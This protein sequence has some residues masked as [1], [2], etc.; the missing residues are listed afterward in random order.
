MF[1]VSFPLY[2]KMIG[3]FDL[4]MVFCLISIITCVVVFTFKSYQIVVLQFWITLIKLLSRGSDL[5]TFKTFRMLE[6]SRCKFYVKTY[7]EV[8]FVAVERP[9]EAFTNILFS[10]GTTGRWRRR[11]ISLTN[12][13]DYWHCI[14]ISV[15]GILNIIMKQYP[16]LFYS[17]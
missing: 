11:N 8:E 3:I 2:L 7:R 4:I 15:F 1:H 14:S 10:S 5:K 9:V 16:L 12:F 13:L 17:S 6:D